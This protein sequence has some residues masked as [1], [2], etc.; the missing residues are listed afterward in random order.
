MGGYTLREMT[1]DGFDAVELGTA[2]ARLVLVTGCGPRIAFFGRPDGENLLYWQR[3]GVVSGEWRLHGGHRVW[4]TRPYADEAVDAYMGDNEPCAREVSGGRVRAVSPPHPFFRIARGME[5]EQLAENRFAVTNFIVNEGPLIY[6][7]G[8]WSP[9][10]IVPDGGVISVDLGQ[11][12]ATWDAVQLV[13]PRKFA[14]N[15]VRIDDPQVTFTERQMHVTPRGVLTKRCVCAPKGRVAAQWRDKGL[16][17]SKQAQYCP[18]G[19][20]PLNGCN[21]AVFVGADN[22]MAEMETFGPEQPIPPGGTLGNREIW[23]LTAL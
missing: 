22:W 7:G 17:F 9:T 3:D 8:V 6:S 16:C 23:E 13:I 18:G 15:T 11:D 4:I 5:V 12:E 21:V 10:C 19:H 14:G 2:A 20:Y 1:F